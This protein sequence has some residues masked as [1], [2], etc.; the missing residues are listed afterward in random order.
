MPETKSELYRALTSDGGRS[1][2]DTDCPRDTPVEKLS[3][4]TMV[5][6]RV[7]TVKFNVWSMGSNTLVH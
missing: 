7:L 6:I 2:K 4:R 1:A 3:K 5:Q